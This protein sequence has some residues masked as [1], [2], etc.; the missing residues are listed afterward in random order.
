MIHLS[1]KRIKK[2]KQFNY[3]LVNIEVDAIPT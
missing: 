3:E 2:T 1:R